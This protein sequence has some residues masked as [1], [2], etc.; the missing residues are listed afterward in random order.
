MS[1]W[2]RYIIL[3]AVGAVLFLPFLGATPLF[4]WDEANFAEASREM[5]ATGNYLQVQI[6]F[7]PFYEK[8]PL[9]FWVQ[10]WIM[11]TIGV[12]EAAARLPSA[13]TGIIVLPL[14]FGVGRSVEDDR[15]GLLWAL[16]Y[17]GS[18][19]PSFYFHTGVIDPMFNLLMFAAVLLLFHSMTNSQATSEVRQLRWALLA[20][21]CSGLAVL[22]KGPVGL[23]IPALVWMAVWLIHRRSTPLPWREALLFL[24]TSILVGSSWFILEWVSHG[25]GFLQQFVEYQRRLLETG[26]AGHGEPW[27]Y[28]LVVV[29]IGC[30]P[31]S[32]MALGGMRPSQS[33]S[34]QRTLFHW[35]MLVLLFVVLI[36]FSAVRTKIV[37]YSSLA[38]YPVTFFAAVFLHR[39]WKEH[40]RPHLL[41]TLA[42]V[43]MGL[44]W[45]T[46]MTAF[47]L[48]MKHKDLWI[49]R[50]KD[51]FARA[52]IAAPVQWGMVDTVPGLILLGTAIVA[53]ILVIRRRRLPAMLTLFGGTMLAMWLF[54]PIVVPKLHEHVQG[55]MLKFFRTQGPRDVYVRAIGFR[56]YAQYFYGAQRIDQSPRHM[57]I[58]PED[59]EKWLLTGP[60][61]KPAYFVCK[62][63]DAPT[64]RRILGAGYGEENGYVFFKRMPG[65]R[66][67]NS[68]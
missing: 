8:P 38:Y 35:W 36:V 28:H 46:A 43:A 37:H 19:L 16:A 13:L 14:L 33:E 6:G 39:A 40:T 49:D 24:T 25:G 58:A 34:P 11:S 61:D 56:S 59:F 5:L 54:L 41:P 57:G 26:E 44:L 7:E 27:Y 3:A 30:F 67:A 62:I 42:A 21:I 12:N 64:Y 4:D 9:F 29:L 10:A 53:A 17:A 47:P 2:K 65:S 22:T 63:N 51:A 50:V 68:P 60:I 20:G 45:G 52:N 23:G 55:S 15:L 31:A 48:L 66:P 18:I 1:T 32:L